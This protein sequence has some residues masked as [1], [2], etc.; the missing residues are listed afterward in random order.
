M[1]MD[2]EERLDWAC[3]RGGKRVIAFWESGGRCFRVIGE[4]ED[5]VHRDS[6]Y[7]LIRKDLMHTTV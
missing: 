1:D 3:D 5:V 6:R 4:E 7:I 2:H